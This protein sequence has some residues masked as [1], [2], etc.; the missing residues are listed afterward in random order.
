MEIKKQMT[1]YQWIKKGLLLLCYMSTLALSIKNFREPDLWW[2][3]RTGEWILQHHAVPHSDVFSYTYF[4]TEWINIKWG[5]EVLLAF[6]SGCFGPESVFIIQAL[7]SCVL[8]FFLIRL[9]K[10]FR[11]NFSEE[12]SEKNDKRFYVS[13]FIAFIISAIAIEYRLNGRPEMT[14]HLFAIIFLYLLYRNRQQPS[15]QIYLLIPLQMFW[16]NFHEAF[17]TGIVVMIIFTTA[18]WMER[19]MFRKKL[20]AEEKQNPVQL[21]LVTLLAITSTLF[22]PNGVKLIVRPFN[23]LSQ[24][25]Q[26]KYTTELLSFSSPEY[27][28]KEAYIGLFIFISVLIG[29]FVSAKQ[30]NKNVLIALTEKFGLAYLLVLFAFLYLAITAYR[31]IIFLVLV[32]FPLFTGATET[33]LQWIEK[34]TAKKNLFS[35][36]RIAVAT[37]LLGISFYVCIVT[38]TYY[39]WTNSRDR[40]GL[41]MLSIYHPSGAADY[42]AAHNLQKKKCFSDY[43]TSS[44]LLWKLQP[45]FKTFI[46]LRDLDIFPSDFFSRFIAGVNSPAAFHQLDSIY[47]FDYAVVYRP[48]FPALHRYLQNDSL[49]ALTYVDAVAAVYEKTDS[50]PHEDIFSASTPL[51]I[52]GFAMAINKILNPFYSRYDYHSVNYDYIAATY[53]LS[54]GNYQY[55]EQRSQRCIENKNESYKGSEMMGEIYYYKA[56]L[57]KDSTVRQQNLDAAL[58]QFV[59]SQGNN[60]NYAPAYSGAGTVFLMEQNYHAA[61]TNFEK[62]IKKDPDNTSALAGCAEAYMGLSKITP[63]EAEKNIREALSC[64]KRY[65]HISPNNTMTEV[66][67]GFLSYRLNDPSTAKKYLHKALE[68]GMLS[69]SDKQQAE[70]CLKNIE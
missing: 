38:N 59:Q 17:G 29:I 40:F 14:S 18:A 8:L 16:A 27:W 49:F 35:T 63:S 46:D 20:L 25:Y 23:I 42:I 55:A 9:S 39:K 66:N 53:Y 52:H 4:G 21:S 41:E 28:Q 50:F 26:N 31:N 51:P 69:Q 54:A 70:E 5:F 3:I 62:S 12:A 36:S 15:W 60:S 10:L 47:H 6:V 22:N 24:V 67:I 45:D 19:W 48:E 61:I 65:D 43:L 44:Y 2:Q 7:V 57:E 64:Y 33:F 58:D 34:K 32:A 1:D 11:N 37:M 30:K 56:L 13:F 68:S